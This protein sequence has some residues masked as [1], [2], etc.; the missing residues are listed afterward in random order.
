MV[1]PCWVW[2]D[3]PV[4]LPLF[5]IPC[6]TLT[7]RSRAVRE[8]GVALGAVKRSAWLGSGWQL[9]YQLVERSSTEARELHSGAV[10]FHRRAPRPPVESTAEKSGWAR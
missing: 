1:L 5:W 10:A 2:L 8:M 7:K 6:S 3:A 4:Y 9:P